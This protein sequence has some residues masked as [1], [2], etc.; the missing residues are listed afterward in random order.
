MDRKGCENVE[1][2][3]RLGEK[4]I[5]DLEKNAWLENGGEKGGRTAS[6]STEFKIS[7]PGDDKIECNCKCL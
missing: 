5:G 4:E 1:E 3:D 7:V 6:Q 2:T